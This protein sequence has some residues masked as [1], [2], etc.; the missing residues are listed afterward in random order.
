MQDCPA[1]RAPGPAAPRHTGRWRGRWR[2]LA[3]LLMLTLAGCASAPPAPSGP[4]LISVGVLNPAQPQNIREASAEQVQRGVSVQRAGRELP[5]RVGLALASGDR[6]ATD[7]QT[8]ALIDFPDGHQVYVLPG[9]RLQLGSVRLEI[10]DILVKL[11]RVAAQLKNLFKVQ[12]EFVTA[13]VEGTEFWVRARPG[14]KLELGVVDGRVRLASVNGAWAPVA[15]GPGQAYRTAGNA[16]P[17]GIPQREQVDS[18]IRLVGRMRL[19]LLR[20][21]PPPPP[22]PRPR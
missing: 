7:G 17:V 18:I 5:A 10:G 8:L 22:P 11:E 20:L 14:D 19:D 2:G 6:L 1:A 16:A 4:L 21:P 12:T 3:A 15:V 13:G 9:T